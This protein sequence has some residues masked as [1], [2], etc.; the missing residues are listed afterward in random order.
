M[1]WFHPRYFLG[2]AEL[3]KRAVGL[4]RV[5]GIYHGNNQFWLT[6]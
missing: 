2:I 1:R 6:I 4:P 3:D 5:K